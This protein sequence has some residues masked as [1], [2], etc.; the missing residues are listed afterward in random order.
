[1]SDGDRGTKEICEIITMKDKILLNYLI[2]R[3]EE[4]GKS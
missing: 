1:M 2:N 4:L 3:V